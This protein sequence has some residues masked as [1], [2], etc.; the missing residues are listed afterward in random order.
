[1][2]YASPKRE[3][4]HEIDKEIY[5]E[6]KLETPVEIDKQAVEDE[7]Q[8]IKSELEQSKVDIQIAKESDIKK[9]QDVFDKV[10]EEEL[11]NAENFF[12]NDN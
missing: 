2:V 6:P 10:K 7:K 9:V 5:K 12:I 8:I 4:E 1:M 3:N 11:I